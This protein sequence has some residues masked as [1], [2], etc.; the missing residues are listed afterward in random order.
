MKD[1]AEQIT[2]NRDMREQVKR[3]KK[4]STTKKHTLEALKEHSQL[5]LI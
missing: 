5:L 3:D 1:T 4:K 2:E